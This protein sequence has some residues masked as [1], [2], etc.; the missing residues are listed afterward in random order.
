LSLGSV[1]DLRNAALWLCDAE[2]NGKAGE[3]WAAVTS[4]AK[5]WKAGFGSKDDGDWVYAFPSSSSRVMGAD[6]CLIPLIPVHRGAQN[7]RSEYAHD[8][9]VPAGTGAVGHAG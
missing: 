5:Q 8:K 2:S 6:L 3:G 4:R 7:P 9:H 1:R